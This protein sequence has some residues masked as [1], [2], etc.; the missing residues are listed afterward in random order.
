[1]RPDV[2]YTWGVLTA[3]PDRVYRFLAY[4][5]VAAAHA[6][7]LIQFRAICP[8]LEIPPR[9]QLQVYVL[10]AVSATASALLPVLGSAAW[11]RALLFARVLILL[12]VGV[13]LGSHLGP[14]LALLSAL[15]LDMAIY[16]PLWENAVWSAAVVALVL[17]M[18]R[19]VAISGRTLEA[20]SSFDTLSFGLYAAMMIACCVALRALRDQQRRDRELEKMLDEATMRLVQTNIELQEYAALSEQK[21][22]ESERKRLARDVHDA[23]G[24]TLTNLVMMMEA[25]VDMSGSGNPPLLEHL[26]RARDQALEGLQE[27]RRTLQ[28][29]RRVDMQPLSGLKAVHRLVSSFNEA[30]HVRIKLHLGDA[31]WSLGAAKD[32][33]IYRFVQE[34]I[35]NAL[36]HGRATEIAISF[37][38]HEG[39]VRI[40]IYDNGVG[41]AG[42]KEGFGLL[43]MRERVEQV[44]GSMQIESRPKEGTRLSAWIPGSAVE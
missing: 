38:G 36:R 3:L 24:Y 20:A 44:G 26:R 39:G 10:L 29:V 13:P 31:A 14:E 40:S 22:A 43:G 2:S 16:T 5:L 34:G 27:V 18:Q 12:V 41:F 33:V 21:A 35:S 6:V 11:R 9:W 8:L 37:A 23:L 1:M 15:I 30:T 25:G 32:Q 4:A 42:V 7:A 28:E 19:P 17:V